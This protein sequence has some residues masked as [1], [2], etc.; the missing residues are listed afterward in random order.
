ML[1]Q[2]VRAI[3]GIIRAEPLQASNTDSMQII[4]AHLFHVHATINKA[5]AA[6]LLGRTFNDICNITYVM[7]GNG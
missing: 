2:A 6:S 5:G 3:S 4:A 7:Q 1:V